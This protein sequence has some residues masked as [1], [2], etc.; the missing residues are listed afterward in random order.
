MWGE[1]DN[2]PW[3]AARCRF[4]L[5]KPAGFQGSGRRWAT[6]LAAGVALLLLPAVA[7]AKTYDVTTTKDTTPN[8]CTKKSCTLREAVIASNASTGVKDTVVLPSKGPYKLQI[9]PA[10]EDDE[11]TGDLDLTDPVSIKHTG[12]GNATIDAKKLDR[13]IFADIPFDSTE[14]YTKLKRITITGGKVQNDT[15]GGLK[16]GETLL[17]LDH[18]KVVGNVSAYGGGGIY[19]A[20]GELTLTDSTVSGNR[21]SVG[22]GVLSNVETKI[23]GS[24][25]SGNAAQSGDGGGLLFD[26][27]ELTMADDTVAGNSAAGQGGGIIAYSESSLN[28]VTI[29]GNEADSDNSAGESGGGISASG[30]PVTVGNSIIDGN[31]LGGAGTDQDC[32]GT[33]DSS[34]H[35]LVGLSDNCIGFTSAGD[36]GSLLPLKLGKLADNG[37]PTKTVALKKNS[38]AIGKASKSTSE[39]RDQRGRKRDKHPD[40]GAYEYGAK[41]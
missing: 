5:V 10:G 26:G 1:L 41:P 17:G 16:L 11:T 30:G 9:P 38:P 40:I 15:G 13:V 4:L 18:S 20:A 27:S 22:G 32:S 7:G 29:T 36:F 28:D 37:G 31:T 8:G 2:A 3:Q 33:F 23:Q 21:S 6:F 14:V 19:A 35:N 39:K 12:K 25:I 34:G 24:T